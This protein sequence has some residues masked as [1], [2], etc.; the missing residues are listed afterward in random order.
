MGS[1]I[2]D[3]SYPPYVPPPTLFTTTDCVGSFLTA[4]A[5]DMDQQASP[6]PPGTDAPLPGIILKTFTAPD[7]NSPTCNPAGASNSPMYT[8]VGTDVENFLQSVFVC[9]TGKSG[10]ESQNNVCL[11]SHNTY[12]IA[13][14]AIESQ[15]DSKQNIYCRPNEVMK[16]SCPWQSQVAGAR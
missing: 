12:N 11:L 9:P 6:L 15:L 3:F 1:G 13:L 14:L 4:S 7:T 10:H 5:D 16:A 8:V 2:K